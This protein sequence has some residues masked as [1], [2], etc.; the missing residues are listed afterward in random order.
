MCNDS[1]LNFTQ[2]ININNKIAFLGVLIDT[3]N[4]D[5]F[6]TSTYKKKPT[7]TNPCTL[8]FQSECP[9]RYKRTIIK[10]L[11][12]RA[13]L[14]SSSRTIFLNELKNIKQTL[15]NN[16]FPNYIV[17]TEIKHF[18]DKTEQHNIDNIL[19]HKQWINLYYKNQFHSNYK[20]DEHILKKPYPKNIL[21][22]N[23]TKKVRLIIYYNKFKNPS[24]IFPITLSP[25]LN[26]LI[27]QTSYICSNVPRETVSPKKIMRTLVLPLQL[28]LDGFRCTLMILAP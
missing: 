27:G 13:K 15:I 21:P 6:I 5:R 26:F 12:S 4:I 1:V 25:P 16:G 23:P 2:K 28:F 24:L 9:F 18:I 8:N 7:N 20:I 3:S 10:T 19:K 14:L 11:I 17:D 22:T